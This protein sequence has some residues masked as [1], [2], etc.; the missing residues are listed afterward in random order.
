MRKFKLKKDLPGIEAGTVLVTD[1]S[2]ND[3]GFGLLLIDCDDDLKPES[4]YCLLRDDFFGSRKGERRTPIGNWMEELPE[5]HTRLAVVDY[6]KALI[7]VRDDANGF[8]PDWSDGAKKWFVIVKRPYAGR[9][10]Y[11]K[12]DITT[13]DVDWNVGRQV[14]GIF[15]L[16]YFATKENAEASIKKHCKEWETIFGVEDEEEE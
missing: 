9:G 6:L 13:L 12:N 4:G 1:G 11:D 5:E 15:G 16:P 2:N 3:D 7:T 10:D 8:A 14:N